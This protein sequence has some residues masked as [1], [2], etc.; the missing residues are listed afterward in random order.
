M[1]AA[2]SQPG[3]AG[4]APDVFA[5]MLRPPE[6]PEEAKRRRDEIKRMVDA[7]V[8]FELGEVLDSVAD[9]LFDLEYYRARITKAYTSA[10]DIYLW[11]IRTAAARAEASEADKHIMGKIFPGPK[12]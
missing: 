5:A 3:P 8:D 1:S 12:M 4:S 10:A 6:V 9:E 11:H 2:E 7:N